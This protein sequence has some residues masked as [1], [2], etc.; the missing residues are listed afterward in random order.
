MKRPQESR[1]ALSLEGTLGLPAQALG[2]WSSPTES[3]AGGS[4]LATILSPVI[5][6]REGSQASRSISSPLTKPM[7]D[8]KSSI[9]ISGQ[10]KCS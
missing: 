2:L 10:T 8:A 3:A 5:S 4:V 6:N 1:K 9:S 7:A